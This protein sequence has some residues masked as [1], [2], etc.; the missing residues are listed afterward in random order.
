MLCVI[1]AQSGTKS[2]ARPCL[3]TEGA[4]LGDCKQA[5]G[6]QA[7]WGTASTFRAAAQTV[8]ISEGLSLVT[9]CIRHPSAH[10]YIYRIAYAS[11]QDH[12]SRAHLDLLCSTAARITGSI[13]QGRSTPLHQLLRSGI[14]SADHLHSTSITRQCNGMC[15]TFR[16]SQ[17]T[18]AMHSIA[19]SIGESCLMAKAV[20]AVTKAIGLYKAY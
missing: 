17:E 16:R 20:C 6:L 2:T 18:L 7:G 14:Y 15:K 1:S 11:Q 5:G 9:F 19:T 13:H 10:S 4:R 3:G 12:Q 8:N